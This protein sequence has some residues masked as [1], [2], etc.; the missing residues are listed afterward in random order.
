MTQYLV[1]LSFL[2]EKPTGIDYYAQEMIPHF[3]QGKFTALTH[4]PIQNLDCYV[5]QSNR[6]HQ[7]GAGS[8]FK[9]HLNRLFWTQFKLPK[10]YQKLQAKL[11]FS[12]VPEAPL[13]SNCRH[14][15]TVHDFIP[16]R[17]PRR[18]SPLIPYH[19]YY[20]PQ[21]VQQAQHV[22]CNSEA[23]ARDIH[24]FCGVSANKITPILLGYNSQHFYPRKNQQSLIQSGDRP[25]D[26]PNYFLYIGRCD[27]HKNLA[28]VITAFS[29]LEINDDHQLYLLGST[30]NRHTP[31]LRQ[32]IT[33][34][35]LTD[36]V[37]FLDYVPYDDLPGVISGAIA[38]VF[39]SLWEGFGLPILE[40]MGCGTP[41]ITSNLASMPE[42]AGD[43]AILVDPYNTAEIADAMGA[44]AKDTQLRSKLSALGLARVRQF[45]WAKTAQ[46]TEEILLSFL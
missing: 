29:Q 16:L 4:S 7:T 28:R 36:R 35:G 40:A 17:F 8:T 32:Q 27:P 45:S 38:L 41:V 14:I 5:I 19:K 18:T 6:Q 33:E 15:V 31:L 13:W 42:V 25:N 30:D 34:L 9:R 44:I 3:S 11:L 23:T 39:P 43:A 21:V 20:I 26:Y 24:H 1:N 12:P 46:Q 22:I 2:A 37:K 10:I